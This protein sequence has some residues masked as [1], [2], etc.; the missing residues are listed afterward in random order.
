M[1]NN[2]AAI[3]SDGKGVEVLLERDL[4]YP[5]KRVWE[6][7]TEPA[8]LKVWLMEVDQLELRVGGKI[9]FTEEGMGPASEVLILDPPTTFEFTWTTGHEPPHSVVR[10]DL[11]PSERGT[12]LT[13]RHSRN[14]TR[15]AALDHAAGWQTH[16]EWLDAMLGNRELVDFWTRWQELRDQYEAVTPTEL[17]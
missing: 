12:L 15:P 2:N 1:T 14:P 16:L 13:L 10:F 8:Q 9:R 3:E 11:T 4:P 7:L 17:H 5:P 6:A